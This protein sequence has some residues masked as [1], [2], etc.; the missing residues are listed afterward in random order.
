MKHSTNY[1]NTLILP[2]QDCKAIAKMPAKPGSVAGLQYEMLGRTPLTSDDLLV[3]VTAAR[4][5]IPKD[6]HDALRADLFSRGQPCLR[7]SP[8]VKTH[9]W[10]VHHDADAKVTLIDPTSEQ[11]AELMADDSVTKVNGMK[12]RR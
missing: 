6:E 8:L 1:T 11:F 7:A 9:G 4:R 12:S 3:A 10:A 2:S 5:E